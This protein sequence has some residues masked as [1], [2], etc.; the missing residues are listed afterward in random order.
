MA[1]MTIS[2]FSKDAFGLR[3]N[4]VVFPSR[5]IRS[6]Q[7][8]MGRNDELEIIDQA[9]YQAGRHI[10][11]F[12]DR[13]V[14]KSSL[15]AT[16]AYQYQSSDAEPIFV[17]GSI[18]DTFKT[19]VANI[20][21]QALGRSKLEITKRQ[22]NVGLEWRGL[23]WSSGVEISAMEIA[24]QIQS[25]GDATELL[26]QVAAKHSEKPIVVIDEFDA[27]QNVDERNN[28]CLTPHHLQIAP[29]CVAD[30]RHAVFRVVWGWYL[31]QDISES[32]FQ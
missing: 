26:K 23:K 21:N 2:G 6:V 28:R 13:G 24:S 7:H 30:S 29:H 20:A 27:I 12:G 8:L 31:I 3:L 19:I 22:E 14:G 18:D 9:L 5:P 25:V 11:I 1:A 4:E 10:F 16:A 15:G 32:V 17:S